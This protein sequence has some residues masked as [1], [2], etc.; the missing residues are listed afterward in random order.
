MS[1]IEKSIKNRLKT[2]ETQPKK[3]IVISLKQECMDKLEAV[4]RTISKQSGRSTSRNMIIEDAVE[5]YIEEAIQ[6]FEEEGIKMETES[7]DNEFFDTVVFPAHEEGFRNVFLDENK[8]YYVRIREDRLPSLKYIAIYV[9]SPVSKI[10][11]YAKIKEFRDDPEKNEKVCIFD[12][13]PKKLPHEIKL[14][15]RS[16]CYFQGTKY[17]SLESLLNAEKTDE[18][19][20]G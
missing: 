6:I 16:A 15:S 8:W 18:L 14:G 11:H 20:F 17:T 1:H 4:A 7:P 10:T 12:G 2:L 3:Q 5:A 9:S 19:T 13:A